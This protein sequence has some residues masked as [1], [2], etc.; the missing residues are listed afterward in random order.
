M[1]IDDMAVYIVNLGKYNEGYDA[2]SWFSFPIDEEDVKE[3]IGLDGEYEEYAVH[4]TD[5]FPMEIPEYISIDELNRIHE[6]ICELPEEILDNLNDFVSYY[7]SIEELADNADNIICYSGCDTME[8]VAYH[9]IYEENELGEIPPALYNYIDCEA[10]G[11]DIEIE[12][13]FVETNY[14]MCEIIRR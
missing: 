2:G 9:K 8:D 5:G 4:D 10:Y 1:N 13:Y 3:K 12:G 7:G 14:G 11:R 6:I